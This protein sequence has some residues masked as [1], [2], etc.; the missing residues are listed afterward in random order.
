MRHHLKLAGL[1]DRVEV[2]SAAMEAYHIGHPPSRE[3]VAC[4][5]ARGYD[6]GALRARLIT[7]RDFDDFDL[8]LAMDKG[9]LHQLQA[10]CPQGAQCTLGLFLDIL[11]E[12]SGR[13]VADPYYGTLADYEI[14]LDVIEAAAPSWV[15]ALKRDYLADHGSR[16]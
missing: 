15:D 4:A 14:M 13:E 9:H 5:A 16:P 3:A 2:A 11:P 8:I 12:G 1:A 10:L 6:L 7:P